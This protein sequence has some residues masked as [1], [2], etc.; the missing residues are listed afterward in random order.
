MPSGEEV[1]GGFSGCNSLAGWRAVL[2]PYYGGGGDP[3]G[4]TVG[5]SNDD[6]LRIVRILCVYLGHVND[7]VAI[8]FGRTVCSRGAE[9]VGYADAPDGAATFTIC[10]A[11][12]DPRTRPV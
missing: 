8:N 1:I 6:R 7:R 12:R 4:S 3:V 11:R 10:S 5:T 2:L 9:F